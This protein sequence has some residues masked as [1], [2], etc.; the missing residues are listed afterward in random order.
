MKNQVIRNLIAQQ[1]SNIIEDRN[2]TSYKL[3]KIGVNQSIQEAVLQKNK[4]KGTTYT[5]DTL[6][7]FCDALGV[8]SVTIEDGYVKIVPKVN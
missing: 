3:M 4:K 7:V 5:I 1:I 6:M 2:L 8:E